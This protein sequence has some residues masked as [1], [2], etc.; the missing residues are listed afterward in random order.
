MD[1]VERERMGVLP[2]TE[3]LICISFWTSKSVLLCSFTKKSFSR[4][5]PEWHILIPRTF[6]SDFGLVEVTVTLGVLQNLYYSAFVLVVVTSL[7]GPVYDPIV[8][9]KRNHCKFCCS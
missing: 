6:S 7:V 9:C 5:E 8:L 3:D 4:R 2:V 1:K